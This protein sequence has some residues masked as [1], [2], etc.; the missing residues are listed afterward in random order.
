LVISSTTLFNYN[1][2]NFDLGSDMYN[3]PSDGH[4][5]TTTTTVTCTMQ[6]MHGTMNS[7]ETNWQ[8][9]WGWEWF[10]RFISNQTHTSSK[11]HSILTVCTNFP[12]TSLPS[13]L[14]FVN[15]WC[16]RLYFLIT[17][18]IPSWVGDFMIKM[19]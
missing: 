7:Y 10:M 2:Q 12:V 14:G 6:K 1:L 17:Y 18:L 16:K 5:T 3:L 11:T 15:L 9:T 8:Q 13:Q 4:T 19:T